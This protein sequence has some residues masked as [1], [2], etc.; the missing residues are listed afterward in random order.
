MIAGPSATPSLPTVGGCVYLAAN[1]M[2]QSEHDERA[3]AM[4]LCTDADVALAARDELK[5]QLKVMSRRDIIEKSL[6]EHR[7]Y[8][9]LQ[10][11]LSDDRA[12]RI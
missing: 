4:L 3:S 12:G 10:K 2:S 8:H 6:R 11:C 9:R 1:L 5:R 7:G